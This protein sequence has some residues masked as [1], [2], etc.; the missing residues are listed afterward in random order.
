MY[1]LTA[2]IQTLGVVSLFLLIGIIKFLLFPIGLF[3]LLSSYHK[4][5][6]EKTFGED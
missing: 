2:L 3:L 1:N 5:K 6:E 4:Y